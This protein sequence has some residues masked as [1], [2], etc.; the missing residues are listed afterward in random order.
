MTVAELERELKACYGEQEGH[1]VYQTIMPGILGDFLRMVMAA[2]IGEVVREAYRLEDGKGA[3]RLSCRK[4]ADPP[5]IT[6]EFRRQ[7]G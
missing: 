4:T 5:Q 1:R 2:R 3:I 7:G 6:A